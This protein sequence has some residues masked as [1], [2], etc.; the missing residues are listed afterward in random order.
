MTPFT[1]DYLVWHH[2]GK[3]STEENKDLVAAY[4][5]S[6]ET[7]FNPFNLGLFVESFSKR[8]EIYMRRPVPGATSN[9]PSLKCPVSLQHKH[10]WRARQMSYLCKKHDYHLT[11][12]WLQYQIDRSMLKNIRIMHIQFCLLV[13]QYLKG[14]PRVIIVTIHF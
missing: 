13:P 6:L 7:S 1:E 11:S 10:I 9:P 5:N 2:F 4:R 14:K 12:L 8:S 3:R